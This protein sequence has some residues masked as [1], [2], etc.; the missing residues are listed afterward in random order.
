MNDQDLKNHLLDYIYGDLPP[1]QRSQVEA[2]LQASPEA[3][4]EV[5]RIQAL[6]GLVTQALPMEE[7]PHLVRANILREARKQAELYAEAQVSTWDRVRSWLTHPSFAVAATAALVVLVAVGV[8]SRQS[9]EP[10]ME[11]AAPAVATQAAPAA[12]APAPAAEARYDAQAVQSP[13]TVALG[14]A[15]GGAEA[16]RSE[17]APPADTLDSVLD[18]DAKAEVA[19]GGEGAA[20][21]DNTLNRAT[22][23]REVTQQARLDAPA[24]L[25]AAG[26][27]IEPLTD[28]NLELAKADRAEAEPAQAEAAQAPGASMAQGTRNMANA[29]GVD[30]WAA[31]KD[32]DKGAAPSQPNARSNAASARSGSWGSSASGLDLNSLGNSGGGSL[33]NSGSSYGERY[34]G[35]SYNDGLLLEDQA[36]DGSATPK[37][38]AER[39][40]T[41][42]A[43]EKK[44]AQAAWDLQRSED[45]YNR[46]LLRQQRGDLSGAASGF[47]EVVQNAPRGSSYHMQGLFSRGFNQQRLGNHGDA[48]G[49]FRAMLAQYPQSPRADEARFYL[50]KS[51]LAQDPQSEEARLLL[52]DLKGGGG[53]GTLARE[54]EETWNRAFGRAQDKKAAPTK[55]APARKTKDKRSYD[56]E[57]ES[58]APAKESMETF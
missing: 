15:E 58:P 40:P 45:A 17:P 57:A 5:R 6:R 43:E 34:G 47:D 14:E 19:A 26:K 27:P 38:G 30:A 9:G 11:A 7:A 4:E 36:A 20:E 24:P 18:E 16:P 29:S 39:S 13:P 1:E 22:R 37:G 25:P 44:E 42:A 52:D 48:V 56:F 33:G 54:A 28:K 35:N 49:S 2:A 46:A 32:A 50:A 51:L 21:E 41:P 3:R 55:Q 53:G 23:Q 10:A 8:D 31:E 12:D